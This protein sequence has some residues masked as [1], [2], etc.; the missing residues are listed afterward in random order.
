MKQ[1]QNCKKIP[2]RILVPAGLLFV[3]LFL[4]YGPFESFR[5]LWINTAMYSSRLKFIEKM[6]YTEKYIEQVLARNEPVEDRRTDDST[7]TNKWDDGIL[8]SEIEGNYYK[9]CIIKISD[10]RR[11][12][13]TRSMA[14]EGNLLEQISEKN[15]CLGGINASG[16]L[17]IKHRGIAWGITIVDGQI[18]S[19]CSH[20]TRHIIGGFNADYKMVVGRFTE[21]EIAKQNYLWAFEF[22]PL[23]I[24]N[25]VKMEFS[26]YS[27]GLA[28]RTAIG[29][30]AEGH[31]FLVV[32]DGR[33]KTSIGATFRDL[34]AILHENGAV[35]A[36][37]LD[38]GSS[39]TMVYQGA[40]VNNPSDEDSERLIPNAILFR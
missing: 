7:L 11:L 10:P 2:R 18:V 29:Q 3:F 23:L 24:V 22:G 12:F 27:G 17:D 13:F 38:G 15:N 9:G 1:K 4:F 16:Y 39:T 40:V 25:G 36:I 26:P 30:T 28:P 20:G 32:V 14:I 8:F 19:N 34:Q 5:L 37:N 35:N 21:D 31:I 6:L 33:Q